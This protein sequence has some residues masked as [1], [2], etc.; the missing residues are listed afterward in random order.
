MNAAEAMYFHKAPNA[1][2]VA[3]WERERMN[4]IAAKA[5]EFAR[6]YDR[7]SGSRRLTV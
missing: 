1:H 4:R 3:Y 5:R 7:R 2:V 6:D